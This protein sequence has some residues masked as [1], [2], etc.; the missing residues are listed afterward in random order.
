MYKNYLIK[1]EEAGKNVYSVLF[2]HH[3][4]YTVELDTVALSPYDAK[5][6]LLILIHF[7]KDINFKYESFIKTIFVNFIFTSTFLIDY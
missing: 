6:Y 3:N 1:S 4:L 7:F 5:R 2:K